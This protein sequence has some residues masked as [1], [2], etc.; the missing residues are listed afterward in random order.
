MY[1]YNCTHKI[2]YYI[3]YIYIYYIHIYIYVHVHMYS[4]LQIQLKV[5][6][7]IGR[8]A[9]ANA[10]ISAHKDSTLHS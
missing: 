10:N 3:Y 4:T 1:M 8:K 2:I 7:R 5:H 9:D 6:S